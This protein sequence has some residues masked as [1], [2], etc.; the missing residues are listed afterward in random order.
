M[1]MNSKERQ[2]MLIN[3]WVLATAIAVA[4]IAAGADDLIITDGGKSGA[5]IVVAAQAGVWE[6]RAAADL[7]RC[8][9]LMSGA[10]VPVTN[11]AGDG[12][13]IFVGAAAIEADASLKDALAGVAKEN[14]V[15][16]AD[17]IVMRHKGDRV[18]LA[19]A[20]DD[21]HY[22]AVA[23]LLQDWGCRWYF[24]TDFGECIPEQPKLTVGALDRAYA[25]PFE[26]RHYWLSWNA[27][28][29]GA[30]DFRRRNFMTETSLAGMG[31][32]LGSYTKKLVPAGKNIFNVPLAEEATAKEVAAQ[33]DAEYAKGVEGISLAIEDG[34]YTSDSKRD[35]ELQAGIYDKFALQPSN[36]DAMM[37][38]YN[39]VAKILRTKYPSSKTR[40]GGMAY[41]N[42]T[43]PPQQVLTVEPNV[44]M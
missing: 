17:A 26:I 4:G 16:R 43:I 1:G 25:P 6:K 11:A 19:G 23:Q 39:S 35:Q 44:V 3:R 20:N 28:G 18:F 34:N 2:G 37:T 31:H 14:P 8:I 27:D 10:K 9:E 40:I 41:A 33:I 15:A 42:V 13:N 12:P 22:F 30:D 5:T 21:S 32:A 29:K 24:P 38:L 7:A 36:T